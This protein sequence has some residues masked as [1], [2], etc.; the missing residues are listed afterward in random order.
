[1][2]IF[3]NHYETLRVGRKATSSDIKKAYHEH[4]LQVHP[5]KHPPYQAEYWNNIQTQINVARD[6]LMNPQKRASYD[7]IWA[8]E[9][10]V[11]FASGWERKPPKAYDPPKP[12]HV[13]AAEKNLAKID[14][15]LTKLRIH[16]A[17][18]KAG[19][20]KIAANNIKLQEIIDKTIAR[21]VANDRILLEYC[22]G[23]LETDPSYR[24]RVEQRLGPEAVSRL[25]SM[26]E[27]AK[28]G[29]T[30]S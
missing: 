7:R 12:P 17:E 4:S 13:I 19:T 16:V 5:D 14:Y 30:R 22:M 26:V 23:K 21:S 15:I 27:T 25:D 6:L 11:Y 29:P 24:G 8:R 28:S 9:L 1:M 3:I 18:L 10:K 2:T 20:R